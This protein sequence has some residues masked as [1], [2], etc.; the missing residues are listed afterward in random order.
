MAVSLQ[1]YRKTIV[2]LAALLLLTVSF[3]ANG[4]SN[5]YFYRVY[6]KDKGDNSPD[7]TNLES[8]V[9][10]RAIERRSKI[11]ITL[12]DMRD[13]PVWQGY[14]NQIKSTGLALHCKSKWM[15]SA[16][17]RSST[18]INLTAIQNLPFVSEV[19]IVKKPGVKSSFINKLD[20]QETADDF[21]AY[22]RPITMVNG[23][24]LHNS[25]YDGSNVLIAVLDGGFMIADQIS[26]LSHLRNRKGIKYT[27]DFVNNSGFVYNSSTH[28]TAVLSILAGKASGFI[29]GTA[30]GADYILLKTEDISSEYPCEED[31]W[32]AGAEYADSAGVDII[33]SSLGYYNFDDPALNYKY[34]DL[35][36]NSAFI[37]KAADI[38]AAKGILVVNSAGNERNKVW[39]KIIFPSDGDSVLASGAVQGN[40]LI[41]DF[42]SA[43]PSY[44]RRVK[45]DISTMGVSVPLQT[46]LASF[47]RANGTSFS[48]PVLSGMAACLIQAVPEAGNYDIIEAIRSSANK[49]NTPDSLYGYG[50]PN[51]VIALNK[52]QDKFLRIPE[53]NPVA[54]PNP[55]TG[56]FEFIL[57]ELSSKVTIEVFSM[58]G[59]ML[60]RKEFPQYAGRRISIT[61]LQNHN[62]G[63][64]LVRITTD[65]GT[66]VHKVVKINY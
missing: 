58:S 53:D 63:I 26:S 13:L 45:P 41:S 7:N 30:T 4:Q 57:K 14:L 43:G 9:S 10:P 48:C 40:N 15:N 8:L 12:P 18:L 31:F 25:G 44:D 35:D 3:S 66:S 1:L 50:I 54:A 42:S 37:T 39:K 29:A 33:T 64:Y 27:Y 21:S 6:F 11:G 32:I 5:S 20:F 62:Q 17:F 46:A 38:A 36:G 47:T 51:M 65:T 60:I 55:T 22:D 19:R 52:L 56:Y 61:E 24:P 16:L 49:A 34:S 28:G 23:Y 59:T 2:I